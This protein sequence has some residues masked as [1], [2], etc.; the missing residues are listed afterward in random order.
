ML[1]WLLWW[2]LCVCLSV[3]CWLVWLM[4]YCVVGSVSVMCIL[5][6]WMLS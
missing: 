1:W 3:W 6:V 2:K 4:L 5:F